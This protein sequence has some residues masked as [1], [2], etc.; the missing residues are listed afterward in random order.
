MFL[1]PEHGRR[2]GRFVLQP[3]E[4]GGMAVSILSEEQENAPAAD[5]LVAEPETPKVE[6]P[7]LPA[8]GTAQQLERER[9]LMGETHHRVKNHLQIITSML[10]LQLSTLQNEEAREALRSSQNRVRS[11]ADLHQHLFGLAVGESG[12]FGDF[13]QGL[14]GHLRDCYDM[15]EDR[16]RIALDLADAAVPEEM[17]MPLALS[18]NEM[19]SNAFK[20]AFPADRTGHLNI[21]MKRN[22]ESGELAVQDDGV[23]MPEDFEN[24]HF[25]GLG[26]KILR[27]F[28]GQLGGEVRITSEPDLGSTFCLHFPQAW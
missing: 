18:L 20:H 3:S 27:V 21:S 14:V 4:V 7:V 19:V 22:A 26:M 10:N 6:T 2:T 15:S 5:G 1:H 28:A 8:P 16:V 24:R 12:T 25:T 13:A 11:I 23:G 17:L 9:F